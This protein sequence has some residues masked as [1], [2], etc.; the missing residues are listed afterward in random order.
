MQV[1]PRGA[2]AR[3]NLGIGFQ[4]HSYF[5]IPFATLSSTTS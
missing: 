3:G 5:S 4:T 1:P 2:A